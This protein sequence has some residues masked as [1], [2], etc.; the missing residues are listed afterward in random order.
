MSID[1]VW[2]LKYKGVNITSDLAPMVTSVRYTD[3]LHGEADEIDVTVQDR[4]GLWRGPWC[5]EPGDTME[6]WYGR[7][8]PNSYAGL[9]ELDEP[10]V[11]IGRGGDTMTMRGI[12]V[13]ITKALRTEKSV[14]Y[15]EKD[16][17]AIVREIAGRNGLSVSGSFN[18]TRWR[19]KRQ[20]RMRDLEFIV[21]LG[22]DTDHYVSVRGTEVQFNT[23]DDIDRA[24]P[25]ATFSIH[26]RDFV[27]FTGRFETQDTYSGAK[28]SHLHDREKR[29]IEGEE[30]DDRVKTGDTLRIVERVEDEAQAKLLARSRLHHKNR[31]RRNGSLT[32]VA[33]DDLVAGSVIKFLPDFGEWA[34]RYVADSSAHTLTRGPYPTVLD[35][36]EARA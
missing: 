31:R 10:E 15:E 3:K 33:R 21:A 23:V 24:A 19:T 4:D 11:S 2:V 32:V 5:P 1:P 34:G 18:A 36:K 20:R 9:F 8:A 16:V 7:N 12:A 22:E 17:E 6:L 28:V 25:A 30:R 14:E 29:T 26:D 35:L 13:P 27:S